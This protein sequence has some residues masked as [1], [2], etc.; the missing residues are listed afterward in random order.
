LE[1]E[2]EVERKIN[3]DGRPKQRK[4]A[5]SKK[6]GGNH[7]CSQNPAC[8]KSQG[9][10]LISGNVNHNVENLEENDQVEEA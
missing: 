9:F 5:L 3:S 2:N 8:Q 7:G 4:V 1:N 6:P 10:N